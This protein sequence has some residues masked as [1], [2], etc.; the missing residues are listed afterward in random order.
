[1][2]SGWLLGVL[3]WLARLKGVAL[4]ALKF[5]APRQC[6]RELTISWWHVPVIVKRPS[7][8]RRNEIPQCTVHLLLYSNGDIQTTFDLRWQSRDYAQGTSEVLL[9][10]G[11]PLLV[12]VVWRDERRFGAENKDSDPNAYITDQ[13]KL[14]NWQENHYPLTPR[15]NQYRMKLVVRSGH[16]K[17]VSPHYYALRVPEKGVSNGQF[18]FEIVAKFRLA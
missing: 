4:P 9:Q 6:A 3:N 7:F 12:P 10:Y 1:M 13:E 14:M 2:E 17:W 5:D 8:F 15:D 11:R 16:R 18:I